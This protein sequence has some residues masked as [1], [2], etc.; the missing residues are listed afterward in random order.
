MLRQ[1]NVGAEDWVGRVDFRD[2][3]LPLVVEVNSERYHAAL[4]DGRADAARYA[5]LRAAGFVV[6]VF[7]DDQV[8]RHPREV[9]AQVVGARRHLRGRPRAA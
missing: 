3:D 4:S 7:T 5:K 8:W 9:L 6:L 1:V 2:P